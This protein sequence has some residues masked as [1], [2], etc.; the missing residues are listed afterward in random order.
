MLSVPVVVTQG[1][2][3]IP[4]DVVNVANSV[5]YLSVVNTTNGKAF[6]KKVIISN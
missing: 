3:Y 1:Y 4:F 5:Y 2:N 6:T